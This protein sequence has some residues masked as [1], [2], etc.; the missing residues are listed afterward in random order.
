VNLDD[1]ARLEQRAVESWYRND[2]RFRELVD[3]MLGA[4]TNRHFRVGDLL[5]AVGLANVM[6]LRL[7]PDKVLCEDPTR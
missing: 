5:A 4:L 3:E 7:R 2:P 6:Y 1:D